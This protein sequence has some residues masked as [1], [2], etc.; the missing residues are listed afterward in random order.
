MEEFDRLVDLMA[1]LRGDQGCPWDKKQTAKA[2]RTFLLEETYEAIDAIENEDHAALKEELGDLLFHV[3]F[4]SQIC[5]EEGLF[6]IRDVITSAYT[7]MYNR[8]PHVFRPNESGGPTSG[9]EMDFHRQSRGSPSSEHGE[10]EG[11]APAALPQEGATRAPGIA[12]RGLRPGA[13]DNHKGA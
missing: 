7:K 13:S 5:K 11:E 12:K 2:F 8:H 6:D 9:S 4:I 1:R 10:R 3:I